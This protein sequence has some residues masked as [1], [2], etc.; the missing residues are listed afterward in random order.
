MYWKT[1]QG[2]FARMTIRWHI[3]TGGF[4]LFFGKV[5]LVVPVAN[6]T[7]SQTQMGDVRIVTLPLS[8]QF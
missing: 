3:A 5:L 7:N 8:L 1:N 6:F 4:G 2:S